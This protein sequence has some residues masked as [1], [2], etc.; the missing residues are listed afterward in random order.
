MRITLKGINIQL[1][2]K[3]KSAHNDKV[4]NIQLEVKEI[5]K[6][7]TTSQKKKSA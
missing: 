2:V 3:E 7:S 1:H 4:P 6:D 5:N